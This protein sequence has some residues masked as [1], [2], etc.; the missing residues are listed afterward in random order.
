[1]S[2]NIGMFGCDFKKNTYFP[3]NQ[4]SKYFIPH[5]VNGNIYKTIKYDIINRWV[6]Y[7]QV[8]RK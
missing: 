2:F 1:M 6:H 7:I 8:G 3:V 5:K 4:Y